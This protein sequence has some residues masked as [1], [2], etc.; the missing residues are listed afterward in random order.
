MDRDNQYFAKLLLLVL[1]GL[2]AICLAFSQIS[3]TTS[4]KANRYM[5]NHPAVGGNFC[6]VNW[7]CKDSVKEITRYLQGEE[8]VTTHD[9]L[10]YLTDTVNNTVEKVRVKYVNTVKVRVDTLYNDRIVYQTDKAKITAIS[11]QLS[12]SKQQTVNYMAV[13]KK[14]K[15]RALLCGISLLVLLAFVGLHFY[16]KFK[17]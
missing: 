4:R 11:A 6:A 13:A 5:V 3:C 1:A 2:I 9:S 17:P 8:I 7:P 16:Y 14:W 12:Q 10:I 15:G